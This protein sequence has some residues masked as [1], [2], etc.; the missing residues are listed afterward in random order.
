[1]ATS[2]TIDTFPRRG[3][4]YDPSSSP[5]RHGFRETYRHRLCPT[6]SP[7][8]SP[9]LVAI[10]G[11]VSLSPTASE[12]SE[13]VSGS[14][15]FSAALASL[16]KLALRG[17]SQKVAEQVADSDS[18][19]DLDLG[20]SLDAES[21]DSTNDEFFDAPES[22]DTEEED[23]P[24]PKYFDVAGEEEP[25]SDEGSLAVE[26]LCLLADALRGDSV[27]GELGQR[28]RRMHNRLYGEYQ[29][30]DFGIHPQR[31]VHRSRWT[32]RN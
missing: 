23:E 14:Q 21:E 12:R 17:S 25:T 1:M 28:C 15:K 29:N 4:L 2:L 9:V 20:D 32:R 26:K 19:S 6:P 11:E 31:S 27:V 18:I 24:Q 7:P 22:V 10:E 8:N 3:I 16:R 5:P 30:F 13:T